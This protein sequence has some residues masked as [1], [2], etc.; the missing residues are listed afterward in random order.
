MCSGPRC[1]ASSC[2]TSPASCPTSPT[3]GPFSARRCAC[4]WRGPAPPRRRPPRGRAGGPP[5]GGGGAPPPRASGKEP[6]AMSIVLSFT[7]CAVFFVL[8]RLH[9]P[10]AGFVAAFATSAALCVYERVSG[11]TVKILEIGSL[12]L[13]GLLLAYTRLAA[14]VWTVGAV[15]L[16]VDLGLLAIVLVSLAIRLPFTLQYARETVPEQ[17]WAMPVFLAANRAISWVW[18]GGLG[19]PVG[20]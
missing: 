1:T 6:Q 2:C 5:R 8:M 3:S 17:Y 16:A 19:A 15:R 20:G 11:R 4:W 12:L 10:V 13:F 9:A 18:A 14:P 7:P